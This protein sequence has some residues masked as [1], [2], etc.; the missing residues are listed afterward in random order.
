MLT[1]HFLEYCLDMPSVLM[2]I[3]ISCTF[4]VLLITAKF[5]QSTL[6]LVVVNMCGKFCSF[7]KTSKGNFGGIQDKI[8][9]S[10]YVNKV[11]GIDVMAHFRS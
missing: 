7:T 9:Y 3:I 2:G 1:D 10:H 5:I 11:H 6:I 8:N 4:N